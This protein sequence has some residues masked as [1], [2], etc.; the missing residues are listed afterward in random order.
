M[1]FSVSFKSSN[2]PFIG[3][4]SSEEPFKYNRIISDFLINGA[5]EGPSLIGRITLRFSGVS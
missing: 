4:Y 3:N 2:R 1:R 5:L